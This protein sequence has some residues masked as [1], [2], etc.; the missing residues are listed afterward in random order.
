MSEFL[1]ETPEVY[2]YDEDPFIDFTKPESY[3]RVFAI[4]EDNIPNILQSFQNVAKEVKNKFPVI[5]SVESKD[6]TLPELLKE[7]GVHAQITS[8]YRPGAKTAQGQVSNHSKEGGAYDIKPADG[9]TWKDLTKEIYANKRIRDWMEDHGWGILE[10]TDATTMKK[11]GATGPHWH[12]GPDNAAI[13]NW[14]KRRIQYGES[15][16]K[17]EDTLAE[18]T[19]QYAP[20]SVVPLLQ[21]LLTYE[22]EDPNIPIPTVTKNRR[23]VF[24]VIGKSKVF[25]TDD[26]KT[27]TLKSIA[28]VES[29]GR[30]DAKNPNSSA[31]G[32]FQ[33]TDATKKQYGYDDSPE[34]QWAAA[35]RLYDDR[36]TQLQEYIKNYGDRG[37][38]WKQLM[39]GMWW[40]PKSVQNFLQTGSDNYKSKDGMTLQKIFAK[41]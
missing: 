3:E 37:M 1:S 23:M 14:R 6:I 28:Q 17:F 18:S 11:T 21:K 2:L 30:Y 9:Y 22:F 7:E 29:G 36:S 33:F 8:G 41:I 39:Y 13:S 35:S 20:P 31:S 27:D 34:G 38:S 32:M 24:P 10:E 19:P 5:S 4:K 15:G 16:F 12:F 40:R 26:L 25:K